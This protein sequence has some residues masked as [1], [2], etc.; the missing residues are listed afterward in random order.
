MFRSVIFKTS[1]EMLQRIT[2]TQTEGSLPYINGLKHHVL[3]VYR[4]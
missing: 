2:G 3:K 1:K 4:E